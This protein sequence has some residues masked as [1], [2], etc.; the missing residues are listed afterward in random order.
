MI[1]LGLWQWAELAFPG[2]YTHGGKKARNKYKDGRVMTEA[3]G[4]R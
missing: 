2:V 1:L 4:W 3:T